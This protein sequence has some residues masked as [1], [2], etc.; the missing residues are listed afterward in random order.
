M[1]MCLVDRTEA[2]GLDDFDRVEDDILND[3]TFEI[4]PSKKLIILNNLFSL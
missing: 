2:L 4:T 3:P 1:T